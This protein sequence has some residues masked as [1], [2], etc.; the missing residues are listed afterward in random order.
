MSHLIDIFPRAMADIDAAVTWRRRQ[1]ASSAARLH[2]RL[3]GAIRT[4]GNNPKR[5]PFA[6]EAAELQLELRELL[7]GR[8]PNIYRILFTIEEQTVNVLRVRHAA[9]DRLSAGDV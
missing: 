1:S 2:A 4:L 3:L 9:Q 5:C 6:D 8:R 7:H